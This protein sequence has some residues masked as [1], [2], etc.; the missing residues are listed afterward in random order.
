MD[1]HR[2]LRY[3]VVAYTILGVVSCIVSLVL[4][5][6]LPGSG[7][8][9]TGLLLLF[10]GILLI[11]GSGGLTTVAT[12]LKEQAARIDKLVDVLTSV[13]TLLKGQAARIEALE[14]PLP[15]PE[16]AKDGGPPPH[17]P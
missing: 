11:I 4:R 7:S 9:A 13:T 1:R 8:D 2:F 16:P 10:F 6:A 14:R 5:F 12:L 15:S 3:L 17:N